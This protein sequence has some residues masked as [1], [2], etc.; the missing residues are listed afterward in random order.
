[1][2]GNSVAGSV[3]IVDA[4][5]LAVLGTVNVIADLQDRLND[6]NSDGVWMRAYA[7]IKQKQTLKHFEP[8]G[9]D[10]FVDDVF[11]SPDGL[12]LYVS[13]SN[14]GDVAAFDLSHDGQPMLWR[15]RVDGFKAD[16]ATLSPDG[17][18]LVVSATTMDVADVIDAH[19]GAMVASFPTGHF[20]HQNDYSADGKHIFNGSIGDVSLPQAMDAQKGVRQLTVADATTFQVIKTY[21]FMEGVRPSV[22]TADEK[23]MY[24]QLSYFNGVAKFDLTSGTIVT[25]V[26]QSKS[27]F[28]TMNYPT[29]DDYPH[30]SAHHGLALSGDGSK[31]CDCGTIDNTVSI[32][33]SA[34]LKVVT[35]IDVGLIPYW[36][37][38]STDGATCYVSLS[39]DNAVSVID[40]ATGHEMKRVM[41][42]KFPQR[43]RLGKLAP[44]AVA[45][46]H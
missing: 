1:L 6:I 21:P 19:S 14:L 12:T 17:T 39:G 43:S 29:P 16:H 30:D 3:S 41:V 40:Y 32:V 5:T 23:T 24:L 8:S 18:R 46:L 44:S 26:E 2:V 35:T 4:K 27:T 38:T 25:Q 11:V 36:A 7:S 10:R 9:G 33:S 20:P 15:T 28:A 22:I 42:G 34:D 45:L 37:T 31:L 13:R